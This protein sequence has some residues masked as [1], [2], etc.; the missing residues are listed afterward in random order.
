MTVHSHTHALADAAL[1]PQLLALDAII[2]ASLTDQAINI[3]S[4]HATNVESII[5]VGA[6]TGAGTFA[7]AAKYPSSHIV[8]VD[9]DNGMLMEV[10]RRAQHKALL[11]RINTVRADIEADEFDAGVAD[12]IWS[13]NVMHEVSDPSAAFANM[14]RSLRGAGVLAIVEMDGPPLVLPSQYASLETALRGAAGGDG[15]A[16]EWSGAIADAG[17]RLVE[18]Q[19]VRSDQIYPADGLGGAYAALELRRLAQHALPSLTTDAIAELRGLVLDLNGRHELLDHVHIR[20]TRTVWI[21][22]RP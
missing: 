8:A 19:S 7:L 14:M 20:G 15:A 4:R 16:P 21:A 3:A 11:S 17:F 2:H 13:S 9:A 5:D 22:R 10:R 6:G 1:L 18:T 12:L